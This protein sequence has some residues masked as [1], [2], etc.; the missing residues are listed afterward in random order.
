MVVK[1]F[2]FKKKGKKEARVWVGISLLEPPMHAQ[3]T[4]HARALPGP[5]VS[6]PNAGGKGFIVNIGYVPMETAYF[7]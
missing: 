3:Y 7:A 5:P 1:K 4:P 6:P 2:L